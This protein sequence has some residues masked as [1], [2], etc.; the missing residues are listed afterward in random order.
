MFCAAMD[1]LGKVLS[2]GYSQEGGGCAL[3]VAIVFSYNNPSA[4]ALETF[5]SQGINVMRRCLTFDYIGTMPE[6]ARCDITTVQIPASWRSVCCSEERARHVMRKL[7]DSAFRKSQYAATL[8]QL[9]R[10]NSRI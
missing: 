7:H 9:V 2:G 1:I 4:H 3:R 10:N 6:D 5:A 8:L